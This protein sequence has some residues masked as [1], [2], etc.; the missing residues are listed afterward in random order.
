MRRMRSSKGYT[1]GLLTK[2]PAEWYEKLLLLTKAVTSGPELITDCAYI[3]VV[4][5]HESLPYTW[6]LKD[7]M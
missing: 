3:H 7:Q 1:K 4:H 6:D 2:A 5:R